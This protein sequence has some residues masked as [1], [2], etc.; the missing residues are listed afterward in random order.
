[1]YTYIL[2]ENHSILDGC[3]T[4]VKV[5]LSDGL[6]AIP[7]TKFDLI[8]SHLPLHVSRTERIRLMTEARSALNP[9]GRFCLVALTSYDL[10]PVLG[11]VFR[12]TSVLADTSEDQDQSKRC[13]V[14]CGSSG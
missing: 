3:Q 12:T 7:G 11:M 10:R 8:L 14:L 2:G 6:K 9:K 5:L 4:N 13:R 1:M